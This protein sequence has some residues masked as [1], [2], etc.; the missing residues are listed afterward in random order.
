[1]RDVKERPYAMC[2]WE[3]SMTKQSFKDECDINKII[4]RYGVHNA[5]MMR[6]QYQGQPRF[7][8]VPVPDY[9]QA[10]EMIQKAEESF[11]ALPAKTRALFQNDPSHFVS[12]LDTATPEK[13]AEIGLVKTVPQ[14]PVSEKTAE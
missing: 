12:F 5:V 1:M 3:P 6:P 4:A 7:L 11:A 13:L 8:E 9:Q 14:T 2:D 10:L